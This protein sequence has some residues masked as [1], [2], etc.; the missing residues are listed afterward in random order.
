MYVNVGTA[1][2]FSTDM[3]II[4]VVVVEV[5]VVVVVVVVVTA[6]ATLT[7]LIAL[8]GKLDSFIH[9]FLYFQLNAL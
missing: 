3:A 6:A 2:I 5:V 4:L 7:A 1:D 8:T 9:N